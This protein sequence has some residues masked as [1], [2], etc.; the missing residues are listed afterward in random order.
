MKK[1]NI[2]SIKPDAALVSEKRN[3]F[4]GKVLLHDISRIIDVKDQKVYFAGFRNGARTKVHYHEG[5]Q[6]LFVTQGKGI[7][8]L[9]K[10]SITRKKIKIKPITRFLLKEGDMAYIPKHV[11]HWHGAIEKKNFSH[12]AFNSFTSRGKE[13]KTFW[14]DSDYSTFA[15]RIK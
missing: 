11:L 14:Y 15:V 7:L 10:S 8:V 13:A 12:V 6:I 2:G 3:Y 5:G 9:Y 1:E 4:V